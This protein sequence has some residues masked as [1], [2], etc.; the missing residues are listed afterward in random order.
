MEYDSFTTMARFTAINVARPGLRAKSIT[1]A[2]Q[3]QRNTAQPSNANGQH[4]HRGSVASEYLGR[5]FP[6]ESSG[7]VE[8]T[9]GTLHG[10]GTKEAAGKGQE[11]AENSNDSQRNPKR[12]KTSNVSD[13]MSI[14]KPGARIDQSSIQNGSIQ[15]E[16]LQAT[17]IHTE[18]P[19]APGN[20]TSKTK[21]S[22][23]PPSIN[24]SA[25]NSTSSVSLFA[26]STSMD[27]LQATSQPT[28]LDAVRASSGHGT[29]LYRS[30]QNSSKQTD[31]KSAQQLLNQQTRPNDGKGSVAN[32]R[33]LR[34]RKA[35]GVQPP[36]PWPTEQ[37]EGTKMANTVVRRS[38]QDKSQS[39]IEDRTPTSFEGKT[40]DGRSCSRRN[41]SHTLSDGYDDF[42]MSDDDITEALEI[43]ETLEASRKPKRK[44]GQS[45]RHKG[46][47]P[48]PGNSE[49]PS[50][51]QTEAQYNRMQSAKEPLVSE[52]GYMELHEENEVD[53]SDLPKATKE[54][55]SQRPPTP[56]P[57]FRKLNIHEVDADENHGVALLTDA[58]KQ[59]LGMNH[60]TCTYIQIF[61]L[62]LTK[63]CSRPML[64]THRSTQSLQEAHHQTHRPRAV[65]DTHSRQIIS[66]RRI[67]HHRPPHLLPRR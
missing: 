37:V 15:N 23:K 54:T 48:T 8:E 40:S 41:S 59:L 51:T 13:S 4:E 57:R 25:N 18:A 64:T 46:Q 2:G 27:S 32:T 26:Q 17:D 7:P 67:Q 20:K 63:L 28:S 43:A 3:V 34:P 62:H 1:Q 47:L 14:T 58:E 45:S 38:T 19:P 33:V 36:E 35:N 10:P 22:L 61:T 52:D 29:T 42:M 12:R 24:V 5:D 50:G 44:T 39:K 31:T 60:G 6:D 49:A 16:S 9:T 65:P 53:L 66:L 11:R 55:I 56:P 30:A 21:G